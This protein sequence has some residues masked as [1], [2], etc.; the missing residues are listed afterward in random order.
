VTNPSKALFLERR[1]LHDVDIS[2][3]P[4][5]RSEFRFPSGMI[6]GFREVA[7]LGIPVVIFSNED[8]VAFGRLAPRDVS[9]Y[10][11]GLQRVLLS[12]GV[13]VDRILHCPFHPGGKG[14]FRRDSVYHLPNVGMVMAV[15]Q[16]LGISPRESWLVARSSRA[17]LAGI[18]A[19]CLTIQV[20]GE[21]I[22]EY[23]VDPDLA[24]SDL[25]GAFRAIVAH[26]LALAR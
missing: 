19:G 16:E 14:E 25:A 7:S 23:F 2:R 6:K 11:E 5:R 8:D 22:P 26:E 4:P 20:R 24:V 18:R 10:T 1:V 13:S 21:E 17:L 12:R 3:R 15:R 9:H